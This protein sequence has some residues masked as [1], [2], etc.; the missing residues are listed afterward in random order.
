MNSKK[1]NSKISIIGGII[2][3]VCAFIALV[4]RI[5]IGDMSNLGVDIMLIVVGCILI[6]S[7]ILQ[8]KKNEK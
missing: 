6:I 8:K 5:L 4:G 3:I 2:A 1:N 7:G